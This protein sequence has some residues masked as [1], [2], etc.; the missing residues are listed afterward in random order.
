MLVTPQRPSTSVVGQQWLANFPDTD[1]PLAAQLLDSLTLVSE[2]TFL[3]RLK[4]L[5]RSAVKCVA[6]SPVALIPIGRPLVEPLLRA[7]RDVGS[8][9][10]ILTAC[11]DVWNVYPDQV[12]PGWTLDHL[13]ESRVRTIVFVTDLIG[14]GTEALS[15]IQKWRASPTIKSWESRHY[16][17]YEIVTY[18][19]TSLGESR[20]PSSRHSISAYDRSCD[21]SAAELRT[22]NGGAFRNLCQ[23]YA[24][25]LARPLGYEGAGALLIL[26]HTTPNTLPRV[27]LR[28]TKSWFPLVDRLTSPD[29]QPISVC[30]GWEPG[31][32]LI[33][34]ALNLSAGRLS[35]GWLTTVPARRL[36]LL[37][38]LL[39]CDKGL[40]EVR[41]IAQLLLLPE[42]TVIRLEAEAVALELMNSDRTPTKKFRRELRSAFDEQRP[43][44]RNLQSPTEPYFPRFTRT[45]G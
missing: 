43:I 10:I 38:Y 28:R 8:E 24:K 19:L 42:P 41:D 2:A 29:Q 22:D 9:D 5:L 36:G 13:R 44:D 35:P 23:A 25:G 39:A 33:D 3:T 37:C 34:A 6:P 18:G 26:Q 27:F 1:R 11:R 7:Y 14:S 17:R 15:F 30:M 20:F 12:A 45:F 40:R 4:A 21:L 16:L 31:S 32:R